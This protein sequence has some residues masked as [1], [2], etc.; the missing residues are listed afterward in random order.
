MG[1]RARELVRGSLAATVEGTVSAAAFLVVVRRLAWGLASAAT[2]WGAASASAVGFWWRRP[3]RLPRL[4]FGLPSG[5]GSISSGGGA[6]ST[7]ASAVAAFLW[8]RPPRLP[9]LRFGLPSA[10]RSV[11]L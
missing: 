5:S 6:V 7:V 8:R 3:P 4:R 11:P 2:F 1:V 10:S 9:R